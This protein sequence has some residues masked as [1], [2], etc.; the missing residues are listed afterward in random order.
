MTDQTWFSTLSSNMFYTQ[1]STF[2][3]IWIS[4]S[5]RC[6][7]LKHTPADWWLH[8]DKCFEKRLEDVK[9]IMDHYH[10]AFFSANLWYQ[11][12]ILAWNEWCCSFYCCEQNDTLHRKVAYTIYFCVFQC[13]NGLNLISQKKL[14]HKDKS[15]QTF[16]K[17]LQP[18]VSM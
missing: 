7:Q 15:S 6:V 14:V 17:F 9:V 5:I 16:T 18:G 12:I 1:L 8:V 4:S 13:M 10:Q 2:R 11:C 3:P